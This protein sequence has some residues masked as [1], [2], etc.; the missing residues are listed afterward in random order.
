[1]A[2]SIFF[3]LNEV[4]I[5]YWNCPNLT[6]FSETNVSITKLSHKKHS[7]HKNIKY[8]HFRVEI[9][10]FVDTK[11]NSFTLL[12]KKLNVNKMIHNG[13][14]LMKFTGNSF[15]F[16]FL[17]LK[18]AAENKIDFFYPRRNVRYG[19]WP[20]SS[21]LRDLFVWDLM[22]GWSTSSIG[23]CLLNANT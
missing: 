10:S 9:W 1:M 23:D 16:I 3:D 14:V 6:L 2:K 11:W 15:F 8:F 21:D 20:F 17:V 4:Y 12:T 22:S 19:I 7:C 18:E 13:S 5:R